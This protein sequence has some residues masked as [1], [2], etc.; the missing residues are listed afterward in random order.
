MST[1]EVL[2]DNQSRFPGVKIP[3][4][5]VGSTVPS[6]LDICVSRRQM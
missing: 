1:G 3:F 4:F 5:H 6:L 2:T